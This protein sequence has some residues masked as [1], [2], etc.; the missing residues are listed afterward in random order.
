M[1]LYCYIFPIP[2]YLGNGIFCQHVYVEGEYC[3]K[4]EEFFPRVSGDLVATN[5]FCMTKFGRKPISSLLTDF[6]RN[7]GC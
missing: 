7:H 2:N 3:P 6:D 1:N 4:M 5:S